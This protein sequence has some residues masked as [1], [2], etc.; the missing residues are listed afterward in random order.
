LPFSLASAVNAAKIPCN[1][2]PETEKRKRKKGE[3]RKGVEKEEM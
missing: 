3:E 2:Y 1:E